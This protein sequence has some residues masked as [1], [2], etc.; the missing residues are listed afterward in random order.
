[1]SVLPKTPSRATNATRCDGLIVQLAKG[2]SKSKLLDRLKGAVKATLKGS[3]RIHLISHGDRMY[4]LI[5]SKPATQPTT[6]Q[7]FEMVRALEGHA[8]I[9]I[10]EIGAIVP[11]VDP[12]LQQV[13]AKSQVKAFAK[14]SRKNEVRPC[15]HFEEWALSA[16]GAQAAWALPLPEG[17]KSQGENIV[18]AHPDTGYT[19]HPEFIYGGRVLVKRG[20]DFED[21]KADPKD[22]LAGQAPGHGTATGS[23]ILSA[24]GDQT[25]QLPHFVTG[26]AP[27]AVLIPIRVSTGVVHLSFRRLVKGIYHAI[28]QR[29]HII[30]M[31]LGGPFFSRLLQTAIRAAVNR[32]IIVISAAGNVWPFVI[33]PAKLDEVIAVAASNCELRPWKK[34]AKGK[35]VDVTAP[36]ESIWRARSTKATAKPF[37]NARSD[38][39]S[40]ATA[41]TAGACATWLAFHGR[42]KLVEKYGKENLSTVFRHMIRST[43]HTPPGW[44]TS[45]YGTGI[46]DVSKLLQAK[47]P[48]KSTVL[49]A[50]PA[51]K[52]ISNVSEIVGLFPEISTGKTKVVLAKTWKCKPS[53]LEAELA[54]YD[55]ELRYMLVTN[56]DLRA[57]FLQRAMSKSISGISAK[58]LA[59]P[60]LLG[61]RATRSLKNRLGL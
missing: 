17:G 18:V 14:S 24:V 23:V 48:A 8:A 6:R 36:G 33:Y 39:T 43:V 16:I 29:A 11:G 55:H 5:R 40:Y 20:Y 34:S 12:D 52:S 9:A 21:N 53:E 54:A 31:S 35:A 2:G 27:K 32:G 51:P 38:G 41:M 26:A 57:T 46:I 60:E 56:P 25:P 19:P 4:E 13:Y 3:W 47:L 58:T 15:S 42:A 22:S 30:S 50:A 59:K 45:Q 28:D 10:A 61:R 1:M 49:A 44:K 37:S 7:A